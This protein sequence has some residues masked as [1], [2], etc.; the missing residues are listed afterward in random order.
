VRL[1]QKFKKNLLLDF[2]RS[3]FGLD[4]INKRSLSWPCFSPEDKKMNISRRK[5]ISA[6]GTALAGLSLVEIIK[7][8]G[9]MA[10][11]NRDRG[12]QQDVPD[13][14][15]EQEMR[16]GF[17][18]DLPLNPDGSAVEYAP[19]QA[20]PIEGPLKW[21]TPDRQNPDINP[22]FRDLRVSI[23]TRGMSRRSGTLRAGDLEALPKIEKTYLMQCGAP[24]PRGIVTWGGVR[25]ADFAAVLGLHPGVH[26]CRVTAA[27]GAYVDEDI[28]TLRHP[29]VMLAWEM[30][31]QALTADHG[32]PLRLVIPFRYGK[33]SIK[34]ITGMQ[35]ATP[36]LP[37]PAA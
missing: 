11:T 7:T 16:Q 3:I 22:D 12:G 23:D 36:G 21:Q 19:S 34:A 33:R 5:L 18:V 30:N 25:F 1:K 20:G 26:Y 29:Q 9:L 28:T 37:S 32:A 14:L 24:L 35:F 6:S 17:P 10:Q 15:V 13:T 8:D 27:D 2:K 4:Y 31:G